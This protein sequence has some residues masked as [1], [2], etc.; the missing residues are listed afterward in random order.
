MQSHTICL[1][2]RLTELLGI[3]L[4]VTQGGMIWCAGGRLAATVSEAGGLGL[5]GSGSMDPET[6]RLHVRK[7]RSLTS[8]PFGVNVPLIYRHAE[9]NLE[10][11]LQEGVRIIFT[12][13]GTPRKVVPRCK[14]AGATVLHVV[15]HPELARPA[16]WQQGS[17]PE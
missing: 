3:E 13:A 9:A 10:V 4:P 11:A 17:A 7:A 12:S 8:R 5:V 1:R 16:P 2:N 14:E 15:S 6:L